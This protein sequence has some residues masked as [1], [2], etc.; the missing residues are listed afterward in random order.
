MDPS[1]LLALVVDMHRRVG[2]QRQYVAIRIDGLDYDRETFP[3]DDG[4]AAVAVLK[5]YG[6]I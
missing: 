6:G 5:V 2:G 1:V 4:C 3:R